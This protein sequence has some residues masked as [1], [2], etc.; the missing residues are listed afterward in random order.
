MTL[1][2]LPL[3]LGALVVAGAAIALAVQYQAQIRL[4]ED[5]E[6]LRQQ[7]AQ[8]QTDNDSLSK[9]LASAGDANRP[10][11]EQ[12]NELL[13]LRGEVS[14]LEQQ[15]GEIG[16]LR[17]EVQRLQAM[18]SS[19]PPSPA[20]ADAQ[21]QE[22]Q[23]ALSSMDRAKQGMLAFVRFAADNQQQFPTTFV[24]AAPYLPDG[25]AAIEMNF[26][27]VYAG[28]ITGI[29]NA[30]ATIVLREKHATQTLAGKW[31]KTYGFADGHA[32]IHVEPGGDFDDWERQHIIPPPT[33]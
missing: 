23:A 19:T 4:R 24:Q 29:T 11:K 7:L 12:W 10:A 18:Q 15:V 32:E 31:R 13:K 27:I 28:S 3:G 26:E 16:K 14:V 8:L 5:N 17:A 22:Q 33:Q 21:E 25:L 1:S 20:N 9:R 30:A 6:S 2:K